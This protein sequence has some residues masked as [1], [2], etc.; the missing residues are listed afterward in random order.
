[1]TDTY[2]S[3]DM[4]EYQGDMPEQK[5]SQ[6]D[7]NYRRGSL[8]KHCGICQYYEGGDQCSQVEGPISGYGV[9]DIYRSQRNPFGQTLGPQERALANS[10]T[11]SPPDRSPQ[12]V[13]VQPTTAG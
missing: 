9:S 2:S 4:P 8:T 6:A 5:V 10:L 12:V 3:T 1:M 11:Q 13:G 7:A